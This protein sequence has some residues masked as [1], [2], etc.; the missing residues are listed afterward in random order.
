MTQI[1][2]TDKIYMILANSYHDKNA[3]VQIYDKNGWAIHGNLNLS[4]A[5]N[6]TISTNLTFTM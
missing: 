5:I 2:W 6:I 4:D 3:L 1:S